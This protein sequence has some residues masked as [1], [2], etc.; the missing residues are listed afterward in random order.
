MNSEL[1]LTVESKTL[2]TLNTNIELL[3]KAVEKRLKDY[4]PELYMGDA[5]MAKK[6]RAELN[7]AVEKIKRT[8]LEIMSELTSPFKNFEERCKKVEKKIG[9]A[10]LALDEIVKVKE[11][12]EKDEKRTKIQEIW[13]ARCWANR[14]NLFPLEK[15]FVPKW[16]TKTYKLSEIE[17]EMN[18]IIER[19]YKDLK[20]IERYADDVDTLKAHY[21]MCLD[22]ADTMQ[23][24]DEL[25]R[26]KEIAQKEKAEREEREHSQRISAQE[27]E[28]AQEMKAQIKLNEMNKNLEEI[29]GEVKPEVKEWVITI[30]ATDEQITELKSQC[31]YLGVVYSCRQIEF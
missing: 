28:V 22:I 18:A 14:C 21:L 3:E 20:M 5:D 17:S 12:A 23:Y 26:Q 13:N 6:D 8:R 24:G 25:Q 31:N 10:S 1:S 19:T 2:G 27:K 4:K 15:I 11:Q 7:K 16:L 29:I 9:Q 30:K